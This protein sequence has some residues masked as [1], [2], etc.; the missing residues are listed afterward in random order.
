MK[1]YF[2]DRAAKLKNSI[3]GYSCKRCPFYIKLHPCPFCTSTVVDCSN[4][5][6]W[7]DGELAEVFKL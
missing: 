3:E 1:I 6:W 7:V 5:G 2:Q 4:K